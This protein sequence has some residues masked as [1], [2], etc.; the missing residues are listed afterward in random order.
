[1]VNSHLIK[2]VLIAIVLGTE[3]IP[4]L[5]R[6]PVIMLLLSDPFPY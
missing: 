4:L 1:M 5:M 2:H 6:I 3:N